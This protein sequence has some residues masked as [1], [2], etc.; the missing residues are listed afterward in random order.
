[1]LYR[2]FIQAQIIISF[3]LLSG[4]TKPVP[5]KV[6]KEILSPV[7]LEYVLPI[8]RR[9]LKLSDTNCGFAELLTPANDFFIHIGDENGIYCPN[10]IE[11][12]ENAIDRMTDTSG[13]L[14]VLVDHFTW[15]NQYGIF[16]RIKSNSIREG[17]YNESNFWSEVEPILNNCGHSVYVICNT[18]GKEIGDDGYVYQSYENLHL[19]GYGKGF[20]EESCELTVSRHQNDEVSLGLLFQ[21]NDTLYDLKTYVLPFARAK[22]EPLQPNF[23]WAQN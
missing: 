23:Q 18:L 1:M 6:S 15:G 19:V 17:T 7:E 20:S 10:T 4:C 2:S 11:Q 5:K 9:N 22:R 16:K 14:F 12:I 13:I 3:L 8:L 21:D